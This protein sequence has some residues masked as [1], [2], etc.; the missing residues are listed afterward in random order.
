MTSVIQ[1]AFDPRGG[2][3][4][5][6]ECI[7]VT[8]TSA[9]ID[10]SARTNIY[11]DLSAGLLCLADADGADVYYLFSSENSGTVDNTNTTAANATQC[12]RIPQDTTVPFRPPFMTQ[13][14]VNGSAGAITNVGMCKYLIVKTAAAPATL[15][16]TI[17]SNQPSKLVS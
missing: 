1:Q 2:L 6:V 10:L 5:H 16:L 7:A 9:I 14:D 12:V 4:A 11:A 8:S 3:K 13:A 15:R 17:I